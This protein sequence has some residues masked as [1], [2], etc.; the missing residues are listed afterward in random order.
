MFLVSVFSLAVLALVLS[1]A[2]LLIGTLIALLSLGFAYAQL[3]TRHQALKK[4]QANL[5][6]ELRARVKRLAQAAADRLQ[7]EPVQLL[8]AD[9][10]RANA[11]AFGIGQPKEIVLYRPLLHILDDAE[12]QSVIGHEM[13]HVL[14]GHTTVNTL[15]GSL[16]GISGNVWITLLLSTIF[17]WWL[18]ACEYSADRAGAL[19]SS[20]PESA[21]SALLKI[22]TGG[23]ARSETELRHALQAIEGRDRTS[24]SELKALLRTHP[25]TFNRIER[26]R[27]WAAT[28]HYQ[29]LQDQANSNLAPPA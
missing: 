2:T 21:I 22:E 26:L 14:F 1:T 15:I 5:P 19:A 28:K 4:K 24:L 16:G 10:P 25:L 8:I 12:L 18:R 17:R 27:K 13:G 23:R 7:V 3:R 6:P 29:S 9:Q 20:D 11:Y